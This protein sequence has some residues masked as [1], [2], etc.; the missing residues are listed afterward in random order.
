MRE[1]HELALKQC[2]LQG[3]EERLQETS[4]GPQVQQ[5]ENFA[6]RADLA[7]ARSELGE[8]VS[9]LAEV[10]HKFNK[11]REEWDII[12][13]ELEVIIATLIRELKLGEEVLSKNFG[14]LEA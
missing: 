14:A 9:V 12:R 13:N 3:L 8:T 11:E 1:G 6:L 10:W 2:Y 7:R 5:M 4:D